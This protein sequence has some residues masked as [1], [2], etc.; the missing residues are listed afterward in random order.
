MLA[1]VKLAVRAMENLPLKR[2][3]NAWLGM[4]QE[5]RDALAAL[6]RAAKGILN[7]REKKALVTWVQRSI[8]QRHDA[9]VA[10]ILSAIAPSKRGRGGGYSHRR[11]GDADEDVSKVAALL[12][13]YV[14][15]QSRPSTN[16]ADGGGLDHHHLQTERGDTFLTWAV[17]YNRA[18]AARL[19]LSQFGADV[20]A[21]T[22]RGATALIVASQAGHSDCVHLLLKA[23]STVD[24]CNENNDDT[25]LLVAC[26]EGHSECVAL[27]LGAGA[28]VNQAKTSNGAT[29]LLIACQRSHIACVRL[30]ISAHPPS[31]NQVANG[32]LTPLIVATQEGHIH[33]MDALLQAGAK[34]DQARNNGA[35]PII[36]ASTHGYSDCVQLLVTHGAT[37]PAHPHVPRNNAPP[38]SERN[39]WNPS[40]LLPGAPSKR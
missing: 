35:T 26:H 16:T 7:G 8:A 31:V 39:K 27:L 40:W 29:P 3:M 13:E 5:R 21:K 15:A 14:D 28:K 12:Q 24:L 11:G 32:G 36:I 19:L 1:K 2:G 25:P 18:A 20:D 10:A 30:L 6:N 17:R 22:V 37:P 38:K 9:Q 23:R 4:V 34:V 33:I